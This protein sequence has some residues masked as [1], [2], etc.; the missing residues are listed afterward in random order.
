ME[1]VS[2]KYLI[3]MNNGDEPIEDGA[4][5]IELGKIIDV[6][7]RSE[8]KSK[9]PT[10]PESHFEGNVLMPG[11][12]NAHCHLDLTNLSESI[13]TPLSEPPANE[14]YI[15][16]LVGMINYRR[17]LSSKSA[18]EAIQKGAQ[19]SIDNGTTCI[20]DS[21]TFEGNYKVLAEM[22][23]RAIIYNE[24]TSG[25]GN[26]A[27]ELFENALAIVEKYFDPSKDDRITAGLFPSA[28]YLLSKNLLRII[29]Q[30]ALDGEIPLK[31]HA[32]E[33]FPEMEFFFDSTGAIGEKLFPAIGW[34]GELPPAHLKTPIGYLDEIGFLKA[35]PSII[36]CNH[37]SEKCLRAVARNMCRVIYCPTDNSYFQ[38]GALPITKLQDNGIPIGI[39][40]GSPMNKM[41][42]SMWEEMREAIRSGNATPT[43]KDVMAMA[44]I[45]SA[46]TLGLE[47]QIGSL[48]EGKRADYIVVDLPP[49]Y[50]IDKNFLYGALIRNTHHF[51]IRRTV[52][53]GEVLKST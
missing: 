28:P 40:T 25:R 23:V 20:G 49:G 43:P 30:H 51:N 29:G 35:A 22:G 32:S 31:I 8:L 50:E 41:K 44:T 3:T 13:R 18:I 47:N 45:G 24:I 48:T 46:R 37:L 11:L 16:W 1:I 15:E 21:T 33:S 12:V 34:K 5:S 6:G 26:E 42:L 52:V 9:H 7:T 27:Q 19:L 38:H 17:G 2:A 36:G 53:E 39:G 10:A 4:I 14:D